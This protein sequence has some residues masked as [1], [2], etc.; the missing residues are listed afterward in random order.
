MPLLITYPLHGI[1][2]PVCMQLPC[3]GV[4]LRFTTVSYYYSRVGVPSCTGIIIFLLLSTYTYKLFNN[5]I[6]SDN[7]CRWHCTW[8]IFQYSR[9]FFSPELPSH[10][11]IFSC[12]LLCIFFCT[13]LYL[14]FYFFSL[15]TLCF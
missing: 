13:K 6:V 7:R 12:F 5:Y 9:I 4:R 14:F 2:F 1:Q 10:L 8:S 15:F 3:S 11:L